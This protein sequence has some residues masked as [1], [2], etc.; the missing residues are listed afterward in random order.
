M[1]EGLNKGFIRS[2][3]ALMSSMNI[4]AEKVMDMLDI[5]S[6]ERAQILSKVC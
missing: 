4:S 3:K 5:P 6:N 2:V 1:A